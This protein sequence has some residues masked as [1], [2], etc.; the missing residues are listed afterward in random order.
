MAVSK[1]LTC[2]DISY[3]VECYMKWTSV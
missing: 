2:L 3:N 1:E